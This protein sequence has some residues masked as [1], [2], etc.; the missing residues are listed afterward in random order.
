MEHV[1]TK[2]AR[3]IICYFFSLD[4]GT[5]HLIFCMSYLFS[6]NGTCSHES[7][8]CACAKGWTGAACV[9]TCP[10][11]RH[12]NQCREKCTCRNGGECQ[13]DSGEELHLLRGGVPA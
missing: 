13:P 11:G 2:A 12:G 5:C 9:R 10:S 1:T 6:D 4:N 7:G 8:A 3:V